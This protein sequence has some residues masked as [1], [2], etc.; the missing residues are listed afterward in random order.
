MP[1]DN[2]VELSTTTLT[3]TSA[4]TTTE[5]VVCTLG[6]VDTIAGG[7]VVALSGEVALV[8][9]AGATGLTLRVR[10]GTTTGGA[11]VGAAVIQA[12]GA[13]ANSAVDIEV[14]DTPGE[15]AGGS[16]VL[17]VQQAAATGNATIQSGS[18]RA[19]Y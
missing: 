13:A 17:T 8:T 1:L 12:A 7:D 6:G 14:Q 10:R 3:N 4:A 5:T 9:G 2:P 16:Y 15:L 19:V 18:L 11:Q